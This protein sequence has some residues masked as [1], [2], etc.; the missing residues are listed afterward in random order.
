MGEPLSRSDRENSRDDYTRRCDGAEFAGDVADQPLCPAELHLA[1]VGAVAF[2]E[3]VAVGMAVPVTMVM[4][5]APDVIR[6]PP[7][8]PAA[9][10][11]PGGAHSRLYRWISY[12]EKR[13]G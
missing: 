6:V 3:R 1:D 7:G 5:L 11:P 13:I 9:A 10:R 8:L 2:C 12:N 4:P